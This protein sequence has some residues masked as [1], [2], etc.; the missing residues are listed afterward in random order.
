MRFIVWLLC[1]SFP[2]LA[3]HLDVEVSGKSAILMNADTGAILYEKH[4]HIPL[5]PAS[6]TKIATALFVFEKN[7]PLDRTMVVSGD[8]LKMCPTTQKANHPP[9]WLEPDGTMMGLR[10]GEQLS[11]ES[12][13]HGLMLVSGNDAANVIAESMAGSVPTFMGMLNEYLQG[14]G[15]INTQFS[16]PH[17]LTHP[18]HW[19][20]AHDMALITKRALQFPQFRK[21]VSTLVYNKPKT[22][23]QPP[24]E[25]RLTNP[26]LRPK[27]KH[28]YPK[29]IGVKTGHTA[30]ALDTLVAAAEHEGRVLIAVVLGCEKGGSRYA[31]VK[32]LFEAAFKEK[33][34]TRRLMG[35]EN[36]FE[37]EVVGSK[38]PL[39]AALGRSLSIEYYPAEEPKCKAALHWALPQLPIHKGQKVAEV[40]ILDEKGLLLQRGELLALEEVKG[41]LFFRCKQTILNLFR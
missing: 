18:D 39:K 3:K 14:L 33:K 27:N 16:N 38:Q 10:R 9:H 17:G 11:L 21:L 20:T 12:L 15:C 7:E 40:H 13:L 24:V 41:T 22:N 34:E 2:L 23:K 28:Y 30:A 25:I 37:R 8:S 1:L 36:V 5:S 6:T 4:A 29:A 31:D 26:L 19:S 32:R 35:S